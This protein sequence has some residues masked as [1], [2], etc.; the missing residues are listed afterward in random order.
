MNELPAQREPNLKVLEQLQLQYQ[1]VSEN[2]RAAQ[3]RKLI[4]QKQLNELK[5]QLSSLS[6]QEP[7]MEEAFSSTTTSPLSIP[8]PVA[9][10]KTKSPYEVQLD[11]LRNYLS[12]L[13][14]KYTEKHPDILIAKKK[15]ADLENQIQKIK[16]SEAE[17]E[18]LKVEKVEEKAIPS[19]PRMV[20]TPE[21]LK[22]EKSEEKVGLESNPFY[23]EMESQLVATDFEIKR[24]RDEESK[25]KVRIG[26][27]HIRVENTPIRELAM[28]DLTRDYQNLQE[29]YQSLL[30]KSQE[31]QQAENL[32]RR[33]KGEQFK[34]IDPAR[35]PEK[36]F[37]PNIPRILLFGFL[38]GMCSG[39]GIA[40]FREQMDRSFKD[41]EDLET[42]LGFKVLANIPEVEK[43]AA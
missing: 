22:K 32:E 30:R 7:V 39:F 33:Q 35:I 27:V 34:V 14:T 8:S 25:I 3:D 43:K 20:S 4:I 23:K 26:E 37:K 15:I 31:A 19:P 10:L 41:A 40:F 29:T 12:D 17:E 6:N 24:L 2:L 28:V 5:L 13:Q 42:T 38:L 1:R 36:P 21:T 18:K 16:A 9:K 11:Q